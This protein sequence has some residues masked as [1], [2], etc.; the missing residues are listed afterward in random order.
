VI[1]L[2]LACA[3]EDARVD[4][5]P[6][7]AACA[8]MDLTLAQE[9]PE[10]ALPN[11]APVDGTQPGVA[12][13]DLD[14]DG[15]L[16]VFLAF[17]GG[18]LGLR[19]DGTGALVEAGGFTLDG[20]ALPWGESV[21]LA[22]IDGDG[23]LDAHL[24]RWGAVDLLLVNDGT[25]DFAATELVGSEGATFS[26][27]FADADGDGDLDL[28]VGA[29]AVDMTFEAIQAGDQV[30]DPNLLYLRGDD[31]AYT[32][33]AEAMPPDTLNGITFQGAWVDVEH[34]GDLDLYVAN[35]GGPFLEPNHLLLNDGAARFTEAAACFCDLSMFSMGVA[36]GDPDGNGFADLYI[37]DVG[38]PNLLLSQGDTTFVDAT[39]ALGADIPPEPTSMVSWGTGFVDLDGDQALDLVVTFGRSGKN[40]VGATEIGS[41]WV[42]GDEQPDVV[43]LGGPDGHFTRA[44]GLG[45]ADPARTRAMAVGDLD[46][47]GR[48]D[49]V[50]AGK[51]F[52]KS[53]RTSGGCGPGLTITLEAGPLD[54]HGLGARVTAEAN[55]VAT[56]QWMLPGATGSSSAPELY[57]GLGGAPAADR[58]TVRWVD[59]AETV[60]SGETLEAGGRLTIA[61]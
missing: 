3:A 23:D 56:H 39:Y 22:D 30:G 27:A 14:G 4:D 15:W 40:F 49:V 25:G 11:A 31:G 17:A 59:G 48:P 2:L 36:V 51:H 16:D 20:G 34:D 26:S 41:D 13:G 37:T 60:V 46:R 44:T 29:G 35:D 7:A 8:A 54:R 24:G 50:T 55:G 42:D 58:V 57:F 6:G 47:D 45:F 38:G 43:L 19:N 10:T 9:W 61:R 52:L 53:W 33:A 32:L 18:S 21:A 1:L 28:F 12:I 5:P